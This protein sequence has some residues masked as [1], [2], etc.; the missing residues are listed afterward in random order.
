LAVPCETGPAALTTGGTGGAAGVAI[1]E[2]VVIEATFAAVSTGET[3]TGSTVLVFCSATSS[4]AAREICSSRSSTEKPSSNALKSMSISRSS[5]KSISSACSSAFST[6]RSSFCALDLEAIVCLPRTHYCDGRTIK[7]PLQNFL[8]HFASY[9]LGL[10]KE[11]GDFR[12]Y[13]KL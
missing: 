11:I 12:R 9:L 13:L 7:R 5:P 4:S 2:A 6:S 8:R 1:T 10:V 3:A